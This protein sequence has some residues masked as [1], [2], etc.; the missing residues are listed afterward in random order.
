MEATYASSLFSLEFFFEKVE[1]RLGFKVA[2]VRGACRYCSSKLNV[3]GTR[4]DWTLIDI[5]ANLPAP[6]SVCKVRHKEPKM[7]SSEMVMMSLEARRKEEVEA[8]RETEDDEVVIVSENASSSS[9]R[10]SRA[11]LSGRSSVLGV[12]AVSTRLLF[13]YED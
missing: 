8:S 2:L 1:N 4:L 12:T 13:G 10:R 3:V 11:I 6:E 9:A 5:E 7:S